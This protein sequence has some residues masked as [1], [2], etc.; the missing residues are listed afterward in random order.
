MSPRA[1]IAAMCIAE[2]VGMLGFST[3]P[4][5]LPR[6]LAEWELS[7]TAAGWLSGLFFLGY[8]LAV[9][10][11][12][13]LTDRVDARRVY[14]GSALTT[15]AAML[16]FALAADGFWSA[17]PLR[18]IA[19]AG[20]AGTYMP[21][22][23]AL[24]DRLPQASHPRAVSF[25]TASFGVGASL[26]YLFSGLIGE[27]L[28]WRWAFALSALGALA[29]LVLALAVLRP[30]PPP[31]AA[32]PWA[33]VLDVR[34]VLRNREVLAYTLAYAAHNWELFG[35]RSWIVAFLAF[36]ATLS[37][38]PTAGLLAGSTVAA[39]VN[40]LGMPSS[41]IGNELASRFGRR[42]VVCTIMLASA[43]LGALIGWSAGLPYLAVVALLA[44]YGMTVTG[45]SASVTTG[46]V[47]AAGDE[48]RGLAM[49]LHSFLGFGF[50]FLGSLAP[51]VALDL[52]G[53]ADSPVAWGF[54]FL[55]MAA[56]V[57]FGPLAVLGLA[58]RGARLMA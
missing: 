48:R 41:I 15:A 24:T 38:D 43:T 10:L 14:L 45:E 49:A 42:A 34:P 57:A 40:L 8:M 55:T 46:T 6:F 47:L 13:G 29:G 28:G 11:L 22:L 32:L 56:G 37:P 4:A 1:L 36:A 53:G 51:G 12:S 33:R 39:G 21:G 50:A 2:A 5:L 20:L 26:S 17:A 9:P 25:Y 27:A 19:G 52:S 7:G 35:Y 58:R 44:L 23:K 16:A 31:A 18:L 30:R 54:A 3:Y